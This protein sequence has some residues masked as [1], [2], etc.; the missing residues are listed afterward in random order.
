MLI[1]LRRLVYAYVTVFFSGFVVI[2]LALTVYSSL[3]FTMFMITI[4]PMET[5]MSL[6]L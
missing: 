4:R 5:T 6:S 3:L 2:Q 1:L